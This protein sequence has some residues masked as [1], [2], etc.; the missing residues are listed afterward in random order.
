MFAFIC[1]LRIRTY[2]LVVLCKINF[3]REAADEEG[4]GCEYEE[5]FVS[6]KSKVE[7]KEKCVQSL[8]VSDQEEIREKEKCVRVKANEAVSDIKLI[9]TYS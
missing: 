4:S 8:A 1:C 6:K 9:M 3:K 2:R 7:E 5:E